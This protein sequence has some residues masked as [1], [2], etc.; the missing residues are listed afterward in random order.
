MSA[1]VEI[2]LGQVKINDALKS[3]GEHLLRCRLCD[4]ETKLCKTGLNLWSE[5][6]YQLEQLASLAREIECQFR[7]AVG[8]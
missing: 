1:F 5:L 8:S 3:Y 7:E 6:A 2:Q 4:N